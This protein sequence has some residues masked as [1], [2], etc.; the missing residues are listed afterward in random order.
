MLE[1]TLDTF[2]KRSANESAVAL[3]FSSA[4]SSA[5]CP[6]MIEEIRYIE[7]AI[8]LLTQGTEVDEKASLLPNY[9]FLKFNL[10]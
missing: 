10:I 3:S 4:K 6:S 1:E 2:E 9:Q 7:R 5:E 8:R